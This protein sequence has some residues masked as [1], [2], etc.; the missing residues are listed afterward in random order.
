MS[1][2][3]SVIIPVYNAALFLN[4]CVNS[5]MRQSLNEVEYIFI[6]DASTDDSQYILEE[7][8]KEYTNRQSIVINL[9]K[10]GGI[11]NARNIGLKY[12]SGE[13]VTHCDSDDW[14]EFNAYEKM[15]TI[16]NNSRA[17]IVSCDFIHEYPKRQQICHQPY[18]SNRIEMIRKMLD[19]QIFPSLWISLIR[20]DIISSNNLRFP[21]GLNMGEDLLFNVKAFF[22]SNVIVA[23]DEP[24]YHYRHSENSVCM[25][26]S[27]TST[28]SDIAISGLIEDFLIKKGLSKELEKEITYRKFYSKIPLLKDFSNEDY[29][30]DWLQIYPE[31]H[32]RIWAFKQL[33]FIFRLQLWFSSHHLFCIAKTIRSFLILQKELR[34]YLN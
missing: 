10:N 4:K 30:Y 33:N 21:T 15:Y 20:R 5:L 13:Y 28:E 12:A 2:K 29:Y 14:L 26:R 32:R 7:L 17:D 8:L 24:L 25:R 18:S 3:V 16:A 9:K 27:R 19:G 1:Y 11:S 23:T 31:T 34:N 22:F 6:N